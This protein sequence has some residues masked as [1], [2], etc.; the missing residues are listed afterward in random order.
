M[1]HIKCVGKYHQLELKGLQCL[2]KVKV[3]MLNCFAVSDSNV[4]IYRCYIEMNAKCFTY[5]ESNLGMI[6]NKLNKWCTPEI[7]LLLIFLVL[8]LF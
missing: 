3:S 7:K 2:A 1:Y 4:A 6:Y 5:K 8:F